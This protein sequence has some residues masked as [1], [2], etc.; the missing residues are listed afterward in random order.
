M[1]HQHIASATPAD[2]KRMEDAHILGTGIAQ[3]VASA[4]AF[5]GSD[6]ARW[7]TGVTLPLGYLNQ[8]KLPYEA[9]TGH[10]KQS[11]GENALFPHLH[12]DKK[13]EEKPAEV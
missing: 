2:M 6:E 8:F 5:L 13:P 1:L 11:T 10:A 9:L 3:D 4:V 12:A 7:V